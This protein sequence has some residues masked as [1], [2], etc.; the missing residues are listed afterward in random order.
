HGLFTPPLIE[1]LRG[2][3]QI[4]A[5]QL[6]DGGAVHRANGC[7]SRIYGREPATIIAQILGIPV[8]E[9][10]KFR[11]WSN[12]GAK[13]SASRFAVRK[14][15]P[16]LV[17]SIVRSRVQARRANPESDLISELVRGSTERRPLERRRAARHGCAVAGRR[18]KNY[19]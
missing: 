15:V 3:I 4:L 14:A 7:S 19:G 12:P 18:A 6:L 5:N 16:A 13:S 1:D 9:R 8:K 2:R 17:H 10:A 11:K